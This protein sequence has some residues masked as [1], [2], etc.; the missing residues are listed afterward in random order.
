MEKIRNRWLCLIGALLVIPCLGAVYAWSIYQIPLQELYGERMDLPPETLSTMINMVFSV[1]ILILSIATIFGGMLQDRIGPQK[2]TILGGLLL[3]LGLILASRA[4]TILQ[5]YLF[6]GLVGGTG[7]GF[8]YIPPLATCNKWFPDKKGLISG[9][10][11]AGMGLGSL[12]FTPIGQELVSRYGVLTTWFALGIVFFIMIS[13]GAFFLKPPPVGYR[14]PGWT[15]ITVKNRRLANFSQREML[16][17]PTFYSLWVMFLIGS[18]AGLMIIGLASPIGSELAGITAAQAAVIISLLGIFNGLGRVLWGTVS[19]KIGRLRTLFILLATTA[20]TLFSFLLISTL[21]PFF[22]AMATVTLCFGGF[23]SVFPAATA[24]FY[25]TQNLG[26][27]YGLIFV[28]YGVGAP[29]GMY[30]GSAL[31][32][33]IAFISSAILCLGAAGLALITKVPQKG[34]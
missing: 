22:I 4:A 27:N 10:V 14:P 8:A 1:V 15:E 7:L 2:V 32:L 33:N 18:A 5:V 28:S 12:V 23:L 16:A 21:V 17:T 11:V 26:G 19:D 24:E 13:A 25:G 29:V 3:G 6:Y 30:L 31:S 20:I 9:I 34:L